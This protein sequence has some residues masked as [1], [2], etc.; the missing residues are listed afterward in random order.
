MEATQKNNFLPTANTLFGAPEGQDARIL[1]AQAR[2]LMRDDKVLIHIAMDDSRMFALTDMLSF[3][4]PDV[5]VVQFPAWDCLPYDRVSPN[6]EIVAQRVAALSTLLEWEADPR[7]YPRILLTTVNAAV[8]RVMPR[9]VLQESSFTVR[10]GGRV[11]TEALL[12][13]LARNGYARTET[14]REPGEYAQ[15]GGILDLFPPGCQEPLR[16]DLF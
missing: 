15:R 13:F 8:Q 14:V 12:G 1:A 7:R 10:T 9:D 4:A 11:D 6:N 5:K 2:E 16:I 3:F